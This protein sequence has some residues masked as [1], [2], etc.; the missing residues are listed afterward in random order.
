M[1]D[2][3]S[4]LKNHPVMIAVGCL[5]AIIGLLSAV[6]SA[7]DRYAKSRELASVKESLDT[8]SLQTKLQI[9]RSEMVSQRQVLML[10]RSTL[11]DALLQVEAK[12]PQSR[13][14]RIMASRYEMRL[15]QTSTD[16]AALD[17]DLRE[18]D[19]SIRA[20]DGETVPA[21]RTPQLAQLE[22]PPP[23]E[24][25]AEAEMLK[26]IATEPVAGVVS[27]AAVAAEMEPAI[28]VYT[29]KPVLPA[30]NYTPPTVVADAAERQ[31][32]DSVK[33]STP[34]H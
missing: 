32:L 6:W 11:Q 22:L 9:S 15:S 20:S 10:H 27:D 19:R 7:D 8:R 14:D 24:D 3:L 12:Y 17:S 21:V 5:A 16:L 23:P 26:G 2:M 13:Q 1:G 29:Q 33:E 18:L 34:E 30:P 25:L 28:P 4:K 31:V